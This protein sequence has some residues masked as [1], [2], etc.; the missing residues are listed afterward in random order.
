MDLAPL[1]HVS[2]RWNAEYPQ[3][4]GTIGFEGGIDGAADARIPEE[5]AV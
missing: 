4:H 5:E 1:P 2:D 3:D